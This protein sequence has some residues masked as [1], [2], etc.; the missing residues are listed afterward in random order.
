[1]RWFFFRS[2]HL[3]PVNFRL[4]L[5]GKKIVLQVERLCL[6][7]C[8]AQK[9]GWTKPVW[10]RNRLDFFEQEFS[11]ANGNSQT[12]CESWH[13]RVASHTRHRLSSCSIL[14]HRVW[15]CR[16]VDQFRSSMLHSGRCSWYCRRFSLEEQK[17][18][19]ANDCQR[20]ALTTKFLL[21]CSQP[22]TNLKCQLIA[23]LSLSSQFN[24]AATPAWI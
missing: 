4:R 20:M 2:L 24:V 14:S 18:E 5:R 11:C 17:C 19:T 23:E 22:C 10:K 12:L 6:K 8:T 13:E 7:V 3:P 15:F 16:A 9:L 21:E 1:M